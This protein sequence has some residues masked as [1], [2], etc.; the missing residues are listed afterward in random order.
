MRQNLDIIENK[1]EVI[2]DQGRSFFSEKSKYHLLKLGKKIKDQTTG[3]LSGRVEKK[4]GELTFVSG[5]SNQ[6]SFK[7]KRLS[8]KNS[9]IKPD[10]SFIVR[11]VFKK[12]P[13]AKEA[14]KLKIKEIKSKNKKMIKKID[15]DKDW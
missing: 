13:T 6:S 5:N 2:V 8:I 9:S 3:F 12:L 15:K 4:V 10:G 11:P 1:K 14:A 7:I